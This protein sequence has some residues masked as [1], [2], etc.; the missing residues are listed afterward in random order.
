MSSLPPRF[1]PSKSS[2]DRAG[3]ELRDWWFA[4]GDVD[5]LPPFGPIDLLVAFRAEFQIP[6]K[7]VTVGLRQFVARECAPEVPVTV[8]QRL[9]RGPQIVRK[10]TRHPTMKLSRMQDIG[11]C[12]AILQGEHD[13]VRR[14]EERI[15]RNWVIKHRKHYTLEHPAPSGYR[16]LHIVVERDGRLIEIQLRT[17]REHEWAEAIERTD[18]RLALDLKS[19]HGPAILL[20]Y[21]R[22]AADALAMEDAGERPGPA[23]MRDFERARQAAKP[24]F[25]RR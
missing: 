8:G 11:G 5:E 18:K 23:F 2:V 3:A 10:L 21:F 14:V 9:K 12:R 17:P 13:E 20:E 25:E 24:Y 16:G 4:P 15:E 6:M 19:G 7:K 22:L 1:S